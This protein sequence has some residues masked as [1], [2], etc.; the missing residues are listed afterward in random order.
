M[1]SPMGLGITGFFFLRTF[2]EYNLTAFPPYIDFMMKIKFLTYFV[3]SIIFVFIAKYQTRK[4][5]RTKIF[6]I[7]GTF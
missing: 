4:L 7:I 6:T 1:Q 2:L 3:N 5:T